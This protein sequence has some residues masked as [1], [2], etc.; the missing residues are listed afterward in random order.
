[1]GSYRLLF[2]HLL[3]SMHAISRL[4]SGV[5]QAYTIKIIIQ[6]PF[7][8]LLYVMLCTQPLF[9]TSHSIA[10]TKRFKVFSQLEVYDH[11]QRENSISVIL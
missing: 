5:F 11:I 8:T 9:V 6:L 4:E 2:A 10:V 3:T 7:F 1:V